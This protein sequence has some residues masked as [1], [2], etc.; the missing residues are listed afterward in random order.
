[1][2]AMLRTWSLLAAIAAAGVTTACGGSAVQGHTD[3]GEGI[4]IEFKSGGVAVAAIGAVSTQCSYA[5][6][7]K[8]VSP[9]CEGQKEVFTVADDG[10]LNSQAFGRLAKT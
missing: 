5:E 1:M 9:T 3:K 7:G 2:T 4:K 8:Q 6:S 10:S